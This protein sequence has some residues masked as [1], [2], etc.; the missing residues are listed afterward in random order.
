MTERSGAPLRQL[1][2]LG[3]IDNALAGI[4]AEKKRLAEKLSRKTT[5]L[6]QAENALGTRHRSY[7]D[8]K[9]RFDKEESAIKEEREKLIARRKALASLNNYKVQQSAEKEIE[10]ANRQLSVREEALLAALEELEGSLSE[11]TGLE[12][13]V[14]SVSSDKSAI[15]SDIRETFPALEAREKELKKERE[16]ISLHILP[17]YL[18]N[19][20][21]IRSQYMGD[22][23][24]PVDSEH[25]SCT[26]C[27]MQI[28][29]Q[30]MVEL[31]KGDKLVNCPG[32]GRILYIEETSGDK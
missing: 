25:R 10:H 4:L 3:K 28:R 15:E 27:H 13:T 19:Y 20:E 32:C 30:V 16:E 31:H 9:S 11:N 6:R 8:R 23:V 12:Q 29:P 17:A 2:A 22:S 14:S 7:A 5:E 21:R 24:V 26:G 18:Q 1:I